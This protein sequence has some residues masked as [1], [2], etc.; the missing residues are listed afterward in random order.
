MPKVLEG[1]YD[2]KARKENKSDDNW[3]FSDFIYGGSD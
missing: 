1:N 2:N 3:N